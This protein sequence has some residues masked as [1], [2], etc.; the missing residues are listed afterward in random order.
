MS[1]FHTLQVL[2]EEA[3]ERRCTAVTG[4]PSAC[5]LATAHPLP[6]A[7]SGASLC[8]RAVGLLSGAAEPPDDDILAIDGEDPDR[9]RLVESL[10]DRSAIESC[11]LV[12]CSRTLGTT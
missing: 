3:L 8:L 12:I 4:S 10:A 6:G 7:T 1:K 9:D 11:L 5:C 2:H